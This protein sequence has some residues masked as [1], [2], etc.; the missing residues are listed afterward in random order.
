[1]DLTLDDFSRLGDRTPVL[2]DLRPSGRYLMSE[3][4][5]IGGIQ[6]LQKMLLDAGLLH[7]GC[8]T[9]TGLTVAENL[10]VVGTYP[11]GQTIVRTLAN[12]IKAQSHLA[13]LRGNLAPEGAVAK[14]SG[15]EGL[16]FAGP[17]EGLRR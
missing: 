15:K 6:P 4:I 3:L 11:A 16:K 17:G 10:A 5:K 9:V 13:I 14:V 1:M 2:A 8:L 7:G 12:P